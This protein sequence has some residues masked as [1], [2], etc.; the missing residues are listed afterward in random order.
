MLGNHR[1]LGLR[2]ALENFWH[3]QTPCL[4]RVGTANLGGGAEIREFA[5][6]A[7]EEGRPCHMFSFCLQAEWRL[8][9]YCK[10]LISFSTFLLINFICITISL[11]FVCVCVCVYVRTYLC[12][13]EASSC[14]L[15]LLYIRIRQLHASLD[16]PVQY[17]LHFACT[18]VGLLL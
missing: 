8:N 6:L 16:R 7:V 12:I 9:S 14:V 13:H 2:T 10:L 15:R 1:R 11:L 4:A 18:V 3:S 17:Y 5:S